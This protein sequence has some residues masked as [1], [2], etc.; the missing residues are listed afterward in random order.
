MALQSN[1]DLR[2]LNGLLRISFLS[3]SVCFTFTL[4]QICLLF[5][6]GVNLH[7]SH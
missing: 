6:V 2:L 5:K 4:Q 3:G 7:L 1:A